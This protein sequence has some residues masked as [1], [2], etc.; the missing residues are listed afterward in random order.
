VTDAFSFQASKDVKV[1]ISWQGRRVATLA[2]SWAQGFL[3]RTEGL[4]PAE[5]QLAMARVTGNFKR[6]NER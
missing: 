5:Q 4:P 3:A 6:G 1:F 2:G